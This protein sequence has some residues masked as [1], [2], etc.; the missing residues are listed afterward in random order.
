MTQQ[1]DLALGSADLGD[2]IAHLVRRCHQISQG[3]FYDETA[4]FNITPV[5][6]NLLAALRAQAPMDQHTLAGRTAI[7]RTTLGDVAERLERRGLI[8]RQVNPA[9]RRGKLLSLT[10]RGLQMLVDIEQRMR[11]AE[12]RFLEPLDLQERQLLRSLLRKIATQNND[13]SRVPV[14]N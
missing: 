13:Y 14:R 7:N 3:L 6:Y 1:T 11:V 4:S 2:Q 10:D 9:D 12:E 5:Q 8:L